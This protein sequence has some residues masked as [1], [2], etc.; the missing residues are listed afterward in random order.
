LTELEL[1]AYWNALCQLS[2]DAWIHAIKKSCSELDKFP[3]PKQL[4]EIA[5]TYRT[6]YKQIGNDDNPCGIEYGKDRTAIIMRIMDGQKNRVTAKQISDLID[7]YPEKC[8]TL[9]AEAQRW[10]DQPDDQPF[11]EAA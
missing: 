10:W 4:R 11:P 6:Q 9:T 8:D 7:K 5:R 2:N 3:V 1:T